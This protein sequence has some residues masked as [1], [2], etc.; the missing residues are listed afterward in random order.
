VDPNTAPLRAE[1]RDPRDLMI[2]ANNG[3][4]VAL[5]NLSRVPAWLIG[6]ATARRTD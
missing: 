1:H 3:W 4:V 6:S 5:D 2:C